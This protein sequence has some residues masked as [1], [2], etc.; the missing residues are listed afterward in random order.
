MPVFR[1]KRYTRKP[2][3]VPRRKRTYQRKP[4]MAPIKRMVSKMIHK[5]VENKVEQIVAQNNIISSYAYNGALLTLSMI[6]YSVIAQGTGQGDRIG[7]TIRPRSVYF[8]YVLHPVPYAAGNNPTP[9]PQDV[10]IFFGKVKN[11][12]AQQPISTDFGKLW[13]SGD[14]SRGP[15]STTLDLI[16]DVN[17]D[18]FTVYKILRHKV[19]YANYQGLGSNVNPQYYAN[20]DYKQNVIRKINITKYVPKV[21]KFNDT[22]S[23]PTN[24]GLWMWAMCVNNDGTTNSTN[25]PC[26]MDYTLN[27]TYEDA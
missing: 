10:I 25:A 2:R 3:N 5:N 18:W 20:N 1:K 11:S 22:T 8:N 14:T 17:K 6:P 4:Q 9:V 23:Q 13:Q 27:F 26:Y 24:D 16:Q 19:G 7:N 21:I 12:R 15:F